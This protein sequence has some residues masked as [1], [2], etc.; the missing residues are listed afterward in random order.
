MKIIFLESC[1]LKNIYHVLWFHIWL[2]AYKCLIRCCLPSIH[3]FSI[4]AYAALSVPGLE[5]ILSI[6]GQKRVYYQANVETKQPST[7][8]VTGFGFF[9]VFFN[10]LLDSNPLHT[11]SHTSKTC[12]MDVTIE[13]VNIRVSSNIISFTNSLFV[14]FFSSQGSIK[15][16]LKAY[17]ALTEKVTRRY[18][19]QI[20]QGVSY[21]HS[22]MIVHRDIKGKEDRAS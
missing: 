15:D 6:I 18:T 7:P 11:H 16:Q 5:P 10:L 21:L 12:T 14:C 3:Q 13:L 20:L 9:V 17:G 4:T 2:K 19:R 22:N 8:T 1:F